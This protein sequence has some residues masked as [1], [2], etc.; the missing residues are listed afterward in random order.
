MWPYSELLFKIKNFICLNTHWQFYCLIIL[1]F[2]F[3]CICLFCRYIWVERKQFTLYFGQKVAMDYG[4]HNVFYLRKWKPC[5]YTWSLESYSIYKVF[6][7]KKSQATFLIMRG[8]KFEV[9]YTLFTNTPDD[10][11]GF[12]YWIHTKI[13]FFFVSNLC[14]NSSFKYIQVQS[15][16]LV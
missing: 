5:M 1:L 13:L 16:Y 14:A 12:L 3:M 4:A 7:I 10:F 15:C 11:T 2:Y 9:K 8:K 6:F